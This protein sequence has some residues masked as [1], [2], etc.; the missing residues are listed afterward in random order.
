MSKNSI[1]V[2]TGDEVKLDVLKIYREEH[3]SDSSCTVLWK[4]RWTS[5]K[6]GKHKPKAV[7][8]K[9]TLY[10]TKE[11]AKSAGVPIKKAP[12]KIGK[13]RGMTVEDLGIVLKA[14]AEKVMKRKEAEATK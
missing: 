7:Y 11:D 9:R 10:R 14:R 6:N 4:V 13:A 8:E 1:A 12:Y 3:H 2:T 5:N